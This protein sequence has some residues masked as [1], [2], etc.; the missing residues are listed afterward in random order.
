MYHIMTTCYSCGVNKRKKLIIVLPGFLLLIIFLSFAGVGC[1]IY[2]GSWC[3]VEWGLDARVVFWT[4]YTHA[5]VG[6]IMKKFLEFPS[7]LVAP[8]CMLT[9]ACKKTI[10]FPGLHLYNFHGLFHMCFP[11]SWLP[12]CLWSPLNH[13]KSVCSMI[14]TWKCPVVRGEE[15][16]LQFWTPSTDSLGAAAGWHSSKAPRGRGRGEFTGITWDPHNSLSSE[17]SPAAS[18]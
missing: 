8:R 11:S 16:T 15:A 17:A 7:L 10:G 4:K 3:V 5:Y 18:V 1:F 12:A 14:V 9:S 2:L 13:P 6:V